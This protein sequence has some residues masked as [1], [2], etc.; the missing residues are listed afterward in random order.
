MKKIK[1]GWFHF[2]CSNDSTVVFTELLNDHWQD[3]KKIFDFKY[4]TSLQSKNDYDE[5][6]IAIIEGAITSEKQADRLKEIRKVSKKLV[7]VGACAVTGMPSAQRNTF[8]EKKMEDI[9]FILTRFEA[10][11][12]VLKVSDVVEVD[13]S[14]PGCPMDAKL[15]VSAVNSLVEEFQKS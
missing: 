2:T 9:D 10:F 7:A 13:A 15:F 14:I 4:V 5:L 3:W 11:P 12:K 1:I 6:D 8:D